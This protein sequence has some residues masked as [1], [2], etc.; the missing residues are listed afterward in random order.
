MAHTY[1]SPKQVATRMQLEVH[2][3][4]RLIKSKALPSTRV[5]PKCI[6]ILDTDLDEF[7]RRK[8]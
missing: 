6:R 4:Y 8:I 7:L 5:S 1:L 3:I 2:A